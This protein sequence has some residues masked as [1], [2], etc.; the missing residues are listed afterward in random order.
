MEEMHITTIDNAYF[1]VMDCFVGESEEGG[2]E[3]FFL[4]KTKMETQIWREGGN[5]GGEGVDGVVL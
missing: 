4:F 1:C 5:D 3:H 2:F